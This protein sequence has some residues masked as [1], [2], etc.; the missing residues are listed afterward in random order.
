M[1]VLALPRTDTP[2][3][4]ARRVTAIEHGA[5]CPHGHG[6]IPVSK[7]PGWT[8]TVTDDTSPAG[9]PTVLIVLTLDGVP[10]HA[11]TERTAADGVGAAREAAHIARRATRAARAAA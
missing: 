10:Q 6:S 1:T 8:V 11:W 4:F 5:W 2:T 9:H 7:A 3:T